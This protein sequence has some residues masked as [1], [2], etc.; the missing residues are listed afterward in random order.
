MHLLMVPQGLRNKAEIASRKAVDG[1]QRAI[2][3]GERT[4][5]D[6]VDT[7]ASFPPAMNKACHCIHASH[8]ASRGVTDRL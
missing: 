2:A 4:P 6:A 8:S 3:R 5:P 7:R 1:L